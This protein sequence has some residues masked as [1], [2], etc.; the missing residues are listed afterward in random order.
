VAL[1]PGAARHVSVTIDPRLLA[2]YNSGWVI[3]GGRYAVSLGASSRDIKDTVP[4]TLSAR[5]LPANYKG[6]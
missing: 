1:A 4:L 2:T 6:D 5:N 3:K